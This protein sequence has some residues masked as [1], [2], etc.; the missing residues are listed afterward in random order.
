M[1]REKQSASQGI[2]HTSRG[3]GAYL[4]PFGDIDNRE[5][6]GEID[7][8]K[9]HF[10]D[11]DRCFLEV[12]GLGRSHGLDNRHCVQTGAVHRRNDELKDRLSKGSKL[13]GYTWQMARI[14]L[15]VRGRVWV[16]GETR[17]EG[18]TKF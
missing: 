6:I 5:N 7:F 10:Q 8:P 2:A 15:G 18:G 12:A 11:F 1:T 16:G 13:C 9:D 14:D 3:G 17:F 4:D